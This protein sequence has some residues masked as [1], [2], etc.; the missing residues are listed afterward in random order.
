MSTAKKRA[1]VKRPSVG[2]RLRAIQESIDVLRTKVDRLQTASEMNRAVLV[3]MSPTT[4]LLEKIFDLSTQ[5]TA[6]RSTAQHQAIVQR[7]VEPPSPVCPR[8]KAEMVQFVNGG[9]VRGWFCLACNAATPAADPGESATVDR[10]LP[11]GS[12]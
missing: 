2:E 5:V 1:P 6:L 7:A 3:D 10:G 11:G 12:A 9:S 8:C 4:K